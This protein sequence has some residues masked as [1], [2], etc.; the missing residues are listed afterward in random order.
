MKACFPID[1]LSSLLC[2]AESFKNL[3]VW[4]DFDCSLSKH[5]QNICKS[6]FVH[7]R[8]FRHVKQFLTH[9]AS[10]LEANVLVSSW[11]DY[12]NSLFRSLS[13]F[14]L[15]KLQCIQNSAARI[16]SNTRR[17]TSISPVIKNLHWLSIEHHRVF[18][19]ATLLYKFL[20][21]GF[22]KYFT[23]YLSSCS[24]SY[25]TR[26]SQSGGNFLVKSKVLPFFS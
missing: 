12:C 17:H 5:V 18:K 16:I 22:S 1:I 21:T 24:S 2:P 6:C 23:P 25:S 11:L 15:H 9:N 19:T 20:H 14:N 26:S 4:F 13:K 8:D 3:G 7:L 10:V